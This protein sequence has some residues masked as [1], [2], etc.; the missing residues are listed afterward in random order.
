VN[1]EGRA[2]ASGGVEGGGARAVHDGGALT[3]ASGLVVSLGSS[4][5]GDDEAASAG[6]VGETAR[7]SG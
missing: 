2:S 6:G 7:V 4:A 1:G 5:R 3:L